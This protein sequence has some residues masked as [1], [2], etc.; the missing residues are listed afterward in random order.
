MV[1]A[2]RVWEEEKMGNQATPQ[3]DGGGGRES[4]AGG[5]V[6]RMTENRRAESVR[7]MGKKKNGGSGRSPFTKA[8]TVLVNSE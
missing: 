4:Q 1:V 2:E 7:C 3:G 5:G 6:I 8:G